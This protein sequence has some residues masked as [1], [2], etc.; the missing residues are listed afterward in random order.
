MTTLT[1][2]KLSLKTST[3]E[4]T[5]FL[6]ALVQ[7]LE[8]ASAYNKSDQVAPEVILWTDKEHQWQPLLPHL[9]E[10]LPLFTFSH[11]TYLPD[12][13]IGPAYW[14][15]CVIAR[16]LP[17]TLLPPDV[18]PIIYLPGISRAEI[19]AVEDCPRSLQPIAELQY[20]GVL[21]TQ[22]N[23]RDWTT[24]AFLQ[25]Q[26][27]GLGIEVASDTATRDALS[28]ALLRLADEP[29]SNLRK[30]APLRADFFDALLNPDE[31]R[32]LLL[33]MNDPPGYPARVTPQE[34]KA[35]RELCQR[36]YDFDP[37]KDSPISAA[38][39]LGARKGPWAIVWHRFAEA[40]RAYP[41][42]PDLLD[43]ARPKGPLPMFDYSESW[44]QENEAAELA[45]R[46]QLYS[47]QDKLPAE[48]RTVIV[49]LEQEH[50]IRRH[51]VWSALGRSPLA[52]ALQHL[53]SLA[54]ITER[55]LS[56][57]TLS[58]LSAA[59]TDWGWQADDAVIQAL[60]AVERF[61]HANAIKAAIR[62]LYRTWLEG[63]A[64]SMQKLVSQGNTYSPATSVTVS[65]GTCLLFTD[66][67]R[68]D[69]AQ[70]LSSTLEARG[71]PCQLTSRLAALPTV[72][73]TAK[74]A[75]S[76]AAHLLTAG[77]GF[78]PNTRATGTPVNADLLRKLLTSEGYQILQGDEL[79]DPAG[80]AWAELGSIDAY[81]HQHGWKIAHHLQDELRAI[82]ERVRA[83]L[84][85]GW[86]KVTVIT[87]HGWLFLPG[88]LPKANLPEHLTLLRKGRCARIKEGA[89][90]DQQ[91]VPWLW[92]NN[93]RIALAPGIHCYEAGKEYE[94]GG[95]SPQESI[96]PTITVSREAISHAHVTIESVTWRGLR[97]SIQLAGLGPDLLIDIRTKAGD[98]SSSIVTTP[99]APDAHGLVS[100]IV[101][102]ED[103]EGDVAV[104]VVY[105][106]DGNILAQTLT[107]VGG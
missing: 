51:W 100:L 38:G 70:R 13:R 73:S 41:A 12:E 82:E 60:A 58:E 77:S 62:P 76:P 11:D 106:P 35:F 92:D 94:H 91:T 72:T 37:E 93:V 25:S 84:E 83:L 56:G 45:L 32:T 2:E 96:V 86:S 53:V 52:D 49:D 40:P 57:G 65:Q 29:V 23:A 98:P 31:V 3:T 59:Y 104:V 68:F 28:R 30:R 17:N 9:R 10:R 24:A 87:D 61:D 99:K 97:C 103:R 69:A 6:D 80:R 75:V 36:K 63:A 55:S 79:G 88:D 5:T 48:A 85:H 90:T 42:L 22:K 44:P 54:K 20:R 71:F 95:L 46:N 1:I 33:W 34:W 50:A 67:L 26:D 21:W 27:G 78:T 66:G 105:N 81:G 18:V 8:R 43:R 14:L 102:D 74:P 15:R 16:S 47:L 89:Q 39:M 19:R 4:S 7:A 107:A 101:P 64:T